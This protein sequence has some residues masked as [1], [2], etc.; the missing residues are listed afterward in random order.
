MCLAVPVAQ[1]KTTFECRHLSIGKV[2][3]AVCNECGPLY[4][5]PPEPPRTIVVNAVAATGGTA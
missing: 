3:T 2:A 4:P 5:L 1:P